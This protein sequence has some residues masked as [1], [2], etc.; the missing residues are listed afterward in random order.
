MTRWTRLGSPWPAAII[1]GLV[2]IVYFHLFRAPP[3]LA[4]ALDYFDTAWLLPDVEPTHRHLRIGLIWPLWALQRVFGYSEVAYYFLPWLACSALG[5]STW[6]LG[7]VLFSAR[8]GWVAALVV[9]LLPPYAAHLSLLLPD[10]LSAALFAFVVCLLCLARDRRDASASGVAWLMFMAG[11]LLG[12]SYLVREF[13]VLFFPAVGAMLLLQR[14]PPRL[15]IVFCAGAI[16]MYLLEFAWGLLVHD[17]PFIRLQSG[18]A[19]QTAL[20]FSTRAGEILVQFPTR[21]T[22]RSG[23]WLIAVPAVFGLVAMVVGLVRRHRAFTLLAMWGLYG[24]VLFTAIALLPVV[25]LDEN[26]TYLRM[27]LFRYWSLILAPVFVAAAAGGFAIYD[28]A[29]QSGRPPLS[30]V[31]AVIVVMPLVGVILGLIQIAP[32]PQFVRTNAVDYGEFR[33]YVAGGG[34]PE[35][36]WMD[37]ATTVSA[38]KSL[39]MYMRS[40]AGFRT[41]W[42]GEVA[43]VNSGRSEWLDVS[44]IK[45]G[46]VVFDRS[47]S[48][49]IF[50]RATPDYFRDPESTWETVFR[51]SNGRILVLD[52]A[53]RI[54]AV[55]LTVGVPPTSLVL[56]DT[57][58]T[59]KGI[60]A[61][62]VA[63]GGL[64]VTVPEDGRAVLMDDTGRGLRPPPA[65]RNLVPAGV[66]GMNGSVVLEPR[67]RVRLSVRCLFFDEAG[68]LM[69]QWARLAHPTRGRGDSHAHHA[70]HCDVPRDGSQAASARLLIQLS[71]GSDV[72]LHDVSYGFVRTP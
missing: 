15:L 11:L 14:T 64:R 71:G 51:S 5:F 1:L 55:E 21:F 61:E 47:R 35:K 54:P 24:W 58:A 70:F 46:Y 43:H 30:F 60:R 26:T 23:G 2:S 41:Y 32:H 72:V 67:G 12:W 65:G 22:P 9:M 28:W 4:D 29:R 36:V 66:T 69:A 19:R 52:P 10:Y 13:V 3:M 44:D 53:Q 37:T 57:V 31:A 17:D 48:E 16:S 56:R 42:D 18:E 45:G 49:R 63:G 68:E 62:P 20:E 25:F 6:W 34:L 33:E 8:V 59:D 50:N 39:P 40:A 27:H 38:D 7:R